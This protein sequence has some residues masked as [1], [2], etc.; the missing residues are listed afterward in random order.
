MIQWSTFDCRY[1]IVV[2]NE[3]RYAD[4]IVD[5]MAIKSILEFGEKLKK[6][7]K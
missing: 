6:I 4:S 2:G 7:L 1:L 5:A 3:F